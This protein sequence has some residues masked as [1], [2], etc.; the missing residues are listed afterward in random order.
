MRTRVQ[1]LI[2]ELRAH[3]TCSAAKKKK[4]GV[5]ATK[6][7]GHDCVPIKLYFKK[8]LGLP[9]GSVVKNLPANARD[10]G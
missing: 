6:M 9:D 4:K 1:S 8:I 10:R 2:G 5:I 3:K 7:N